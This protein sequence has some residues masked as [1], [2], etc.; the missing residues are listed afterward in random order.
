MKKIKSHTCHITDK[1]KQKPK[2]VYNKQRNKHLYYTINDHHTSNKKIK[3]QDAF[4]KK[5]Q[6]FTSSHAK[7]IILLNLSLR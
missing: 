1:R 6:E 3:I 4:M 5:Q 2:I 7:N